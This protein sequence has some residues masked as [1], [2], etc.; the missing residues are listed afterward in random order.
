VEDGALNE[1]GAQTGRTC[2]CGKGAA[3]ERWKRRAVV[4][5]VEGVTRIPRAKWGGTKSPI[6]GPVGEFG[7]GNERQDV[8]GTTSREWPFG[9]PGDSIADQHTGFFSEPSFSLGFAG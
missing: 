1:R 9:G 5:G 2:S 6:A 8:G 7:R 3:L 4:E